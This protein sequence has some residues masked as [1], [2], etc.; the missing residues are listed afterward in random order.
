MTDADTSTK[1]SEREALVNALQGRHA[2]VTGGS[3]G[4]GASIAETLA[5]CGARVT[6]I[7]RHAAALHGEAKRVEQ[8]GECRYTF[9]DVS[10]PRAVR[11]AFNRARETF[12]SIDILVNNAGQ[13][14]S[15]PFAKTDMALWQRMLAVNLTGA[16]SCSAEAVPDML[17]RGW[18][19]IINIASTAGLTGYA[20]VTAYCAAKHGLIGLTRALALELASRGITVN[21]ICPGFTETDIARTA[22]ANIMSRTGRSE[23][24]ARATITAR[25]PQGRM[26][27][28]EEVANAVA[29]LCLPGSEAITGQAVSVSGGEVMT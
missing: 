13:A 8:F 1:S 29:W 21:A 20:F 2:V 23:E 28:P 3:R 7:G 26:V 27:F 5:R 4:I 11:G 16:Y 15:A 10:D 18:G 25:N 17:E 14:E 9:G 6:L 12:G 24:Q 19:R 22:I